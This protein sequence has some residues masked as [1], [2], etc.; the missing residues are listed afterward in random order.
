MTPCLAT[1]EGVD[2]AC[3]IL[4]IRLDGH[5]GFSSK[6]G[7]RTRRRISSPVP[8]RGRMG[9]DIQPN[10]QDVSNWNAVADDCGAEDGFPEAECAHKRPAFVPRPPV[11]THAARTSRPG[12]RIEV[13]RNAVHETESEGFAAAKSPRQARGAG[14]F[15]TFG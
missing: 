5:Y 14:S 15:F 1:V 4:D 9:A 10:L 2:Q 6:I 13:R 8:R 7:A 12:F 3:E 11:E